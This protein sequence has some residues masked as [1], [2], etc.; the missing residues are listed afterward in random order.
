MKAENSTLTFVVIRLVSSALIK[1]FTPVM[2]LR[3]CLVMRVI[4]KNFCIYMAK[5]VCSHMICATKS[6]VIGVK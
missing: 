4:S 2:S 1:S 6:F 3:M 5:Q